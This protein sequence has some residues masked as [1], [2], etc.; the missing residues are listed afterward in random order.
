MRPVGVF[1]VGTLLLLWGNPTTILDSGAF[2]QIQ[3]QGGSP[4]IMQLS[5]KYGF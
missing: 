3:T 2:G 5:V 1:V 4:R